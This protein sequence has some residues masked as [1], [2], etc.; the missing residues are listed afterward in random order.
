MK[1]TTIGETASQEER[2]IIWNLLQLFAVWNPIGWQCILQC[3]GLFSR[4]FEVPR[5]G[6]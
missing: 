5:A 1:I 2:S 4:V 3:F 6:L